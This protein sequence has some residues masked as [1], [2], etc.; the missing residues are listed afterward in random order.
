MR[1]KLK[2]ILFFLLIIFVSCK[3]DSKFFECKCEKI[4]ISEKLKI[5][6][7]L[8]HYQISY[9][10]ENWLPMINLDSSG[11]GIVVADKSL[12][13]LRSFGVIEIEEKIDLK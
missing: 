3:E 9:P 7:S 1:N 12:G 10:D 13:Y 8:N 2:I 5:T 11:S 6:D 4:D